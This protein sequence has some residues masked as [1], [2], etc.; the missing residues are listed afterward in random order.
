MGSTALGGEVMSNFELLVDSDAFVGWIFPND[1]HYER[2]N[3]LF[4]K[5]QGHELRIVTTSWI[6]AE[7]ATVLSHRRDQELARFFLKRIRER[8]FPTIHI[9]DQLQIAATKLF[10][11]QQARGTSMPDCANV[12]VMQSFRIPQIFS[13][14]EAYTKQYRVKVFA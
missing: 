9:D 14:D 8:N 4:E 2:S 7:T 6:V 11:A 3:A 1:T 10:E 13:F 12:V 5:I